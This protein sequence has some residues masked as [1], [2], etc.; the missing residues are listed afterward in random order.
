MSFRHR[1]LDLFDR[2]GVSDRMISR[3]ATHSATSSRTESPSPAATPPKL[4][5]APSASGLRKSFGPYAF[6]E[7]ALL[8]SNGHPCTAFCCYP[9]LGL[10]VASKSHPVTLASIIR[11]RSFNNLM[12]AKG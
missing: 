7:P 2:A 12:V 8:A 11:Q 6:G 1:L 5:A 3:L 9:F 10:T 4:C